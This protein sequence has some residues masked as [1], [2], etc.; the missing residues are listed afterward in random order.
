MLRSDKKYKK[1]RLPVQLLFIGLLAVVSV[2]TV[3]YNSS[4]SDL[5]PVSL[6]GLCPVGGVTALLELLIRG[7]L[8]SPVTVAVIV[9]SLLFGSVFCG[10]ICPFGT[11]QD[12]ITQLTKK[13]NIKKYNVLVPPSVDKYLRLFR[14]IVLLTV[15]CFYI[16]HII[17][18]LHP[19]C[20]YNSITK[21]WNNS[22]PAGA[23]ILFGIVVISFFTE[24]PWCKYLCP[25]G[26]LIGLTNKISFFRIRRKASSC[27]NCKKCSTKCPMN[28]AVSEKTKIDDAQCISCFK[29]I[30]GNHC[31]VK[32]TVTV[33]YTFNHTISLKQKGLTFFIVTILFFSVFVGYL[34][35]TTYMDNKTDESVTVMDIV[36]YN[37]DT[38]SEIPAYTDKKYADGVYEGI[39]V[40][41]RPG[42]K[43]LVTIENDEITN[44]EI[45]SHRETRGYFE[46]SFEVIPEEIIKEQSTQGDSISGATKTSDGIKKAVEN[47][48]KKA[49]IQ[50]HR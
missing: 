36:G 42:F 38:G 41:Y 15:I 3:L 37:R 16:F 31:P 43:V 48:L 33:D 5:P 32:N 39:S 14:Y 28:I 2:H 22:L 35:N 49:E 26:A 30:S 40:A 21:P 8:L 45:V 18:L 24:R 7:I 34:L 29:C 13:L 44:I 9:I 20:I 19:L 11:I 46:E 47:A 25:Y 4:R 12:L 23:V 10:W 6:Q 27:I 1:L 50:N 17:T